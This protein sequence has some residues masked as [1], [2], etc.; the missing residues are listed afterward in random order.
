MTAKE[1]LEIAK[2]YAERY[3][4]VDIIQCLEMENF[5]VFFTN[6]PNHDEIVPDMPVIQVF[7][8]AGDV[9]DM[10]PSHPYIDKEKFEW[11]NPLEG[12]KEVPIE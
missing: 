11:I 10:F 3:G 7:K 5:F 4:T 2:K 8:K 6:L 9:G 1:A 12:A